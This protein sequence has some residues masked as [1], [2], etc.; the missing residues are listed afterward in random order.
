MTASA[1][2]RVD[3]LFENYILALV[4]V[5]QCPESAGEELKWRLRENVE[6]AEKAFADAVADGMRESSPALDEALRELA[7][8]NLITRAALRDGKAISAS[9]AELEN[10][11][12]HAVRVLMMARRRE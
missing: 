5:D 1:S 7:D 3:E 12:A 2:G 9:L 8:A 4:A 6:R 10:G 11:T